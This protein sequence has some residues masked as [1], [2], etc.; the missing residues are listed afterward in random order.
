MIRQLRG[1][2]AA[3]EH[4]ARRLVALVQ[5]GGLESEIADDPA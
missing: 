5:K 1:H 4:H 2:V 3:M